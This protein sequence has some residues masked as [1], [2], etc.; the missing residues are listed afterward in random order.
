MEKLVSVIIP[1]YNRQHTIEDALNSVL[2]Q[3]YPHW[4][5]LIIDD[6]SIDTS[7]IVIQKFVTSDPRFKFVKRPSERVKGAA[8][9]RNIGLQNATGDYVQ[10]LDS[11]DLLARNKLEVQVNALEG[12]SLN[13][14]A[15]CRYGISRPIWEN[16]RIITG[17]AQYKDYKVPEGLF[18]TFTLNFGYFPLHVYLIPR[19][20]VEKAGPWNEELTV[21]DDGEYFSRIILNADII[22]FCKNTYVLYRTGAGNRLSQKIMDRQGVESFIY[23]WNKIEK[24][25]FLKTG[26]KNHLYAQG[27]KRNLYHRL[28][29]E[30]RGIIGPNEAFLKDRWPVIPYIS[31]KVLNKIRNLIYV[32]YTEITVDPS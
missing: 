20:V 29:R 3:T 6:G 15:T 32:S 1:T 19:A 5:C 26:T 7:E 12:E 4:E 2:H 28:R 13:S 18:T 24:N 27:A 17:L 9:C 21:N 8:T 22:K 16:P 30:N 14:V 23:S 11:D 25:I 10:Y 31:R